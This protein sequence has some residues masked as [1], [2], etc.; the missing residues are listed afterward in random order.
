MR[1]KNVRA[2][3]KE[4]ASVAGVSTQTV[5]RV[6]NERPDVSP[7][8]RR[9]VQE[10]IKELSYRPSALARSLISQRSYTLG[11]VTAGLRH[12]GPSRTLSGIT[13][14]AEDAGYSLLLKELPDY[15]T[16]DITPIFQAFLSQRVDGIIWAVPEVGEN[17]KW[18][19]NSPAEID[20]PLVYIAM[21]TRE[22]LSIVSVDNYMGGRMAM[23][24]LLEQGCRR[25]GHISGPLDWWEA[26]Q[27]MAAWK[28]ALLEA[29]LEASERYCVEGTWSSASGALGIEMLFHQYPE[30][31][32]IFVANDQMALGVLQFFAE[33]KTRVPEDVSIV[34][35][36]N[37]S[38]SAFFYPS[39]TTVQQDQQLVAKVAVEEVIKII[40]AGWQGFE[41]AQPQSI[42]LT[43][44]LVVRQSSLRN[45]EGGDKQKI[46]S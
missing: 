14:A 27:R 42:I 13:S 12:L 37:I 8:T 26:R 28:D 46:L 19:N 6:I 32:A 3:I 11:V 35:F 2:T 31:D 10:V 43:P 7:E 40:E 25:I 39:L 41:L 15:E 29:G 17:R 22:N 36:D 30:M 20:I 38:E 4:V 45:L 24:H 1:P 5:S 23:S 34:G 16:E 44:S 18:V 21:E 9:R 33:K